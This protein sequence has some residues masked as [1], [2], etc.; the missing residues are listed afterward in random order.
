MVSQKPKAFVLGFC[1]VLLQR[2][3]GR[4]GEAAMTMDNDE[5]VHAPNEVDADQSSLDAEQGGNAA[6][7]Y[8]TKEEIE[9]L[10][11]LIVAQTGGLQSKIDTG[12]NAIRRDSEVRVAAQAASMREQT[13]NEILQDLPESQASAMKLL[14]EQQQASMQPAPEQPA[15]GSLT[16]QEREEAE[17]FARN[18]GVDPSDTRIDYA[19]LIDPS[20]SVDERQQKFIG[21]IFATKT[22]AAPATPSA[23]DA[24]ASTPET[25]NPPVETQSGTGNGLNNVDAVRDAFVSDRIDLETYKSRMAALGQ[26][27]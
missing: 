9:S 18:A 20:I 3:L 4:H 23:S 17:R 14:W 5:A 7:Q 24:K 25:Q 15:P 8:A 16:S 12:L 22:P 1:Y 6:P 26:P 27:V 11:A 10:R 19:S 2:H 21:S 13:F